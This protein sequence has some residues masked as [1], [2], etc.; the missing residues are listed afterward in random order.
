[1]G[2]GEKRNPRKTKGTEEEN[3]KGV[4]CQQNVSICIRYKWENPLNQG[5]KE[6]VLCVSDPFLPGTSFNSHSSIKDTQLLPDRKPRVGG[7]T[8]LIRVTPLELQSWGSSHQLNTD[9]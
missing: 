7:G 8:Y 9:T 4:K 6:R 5:K 3:E 2:T 1:M